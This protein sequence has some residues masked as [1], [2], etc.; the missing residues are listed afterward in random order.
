MPDTA[1]RRGAPAPLPPIKG[2]LETSFIDWPGYIS[3]VIFLPGCNFR[4]PYCHNFTLVSD[5]DS[6]QTLELDYV[7]SRL[8]PFVGWIDGVVV[9]GGEPTLHPGLPRLLELIKAEGFAVKL[10]TNGS[11]P[12]VLRRL[13]EGGLVDMVAMDLKA[14]LD[15][16]AYGRAAGGAV[17]LEAVRSS[18]EYLKACGIAHEFRS[19]IWPDWHGPRELQV[20]ARELA[21]ARRWTLQALNPETAWNPQALGD[22]KPYLSEELA[23]LQAD[24]ADR[25]GEEEQMPAA[26]AAGKG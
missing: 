1:A 14:P 16:F 4:C 2:F 17:D 25:V 23:R 15:E 19:T 10:D 8:R 24:L 12:Q 26:A 13:V 22:G 18:L 5:P 9:S 11:R 7:L 6:Y 21:G 3:A 20:M